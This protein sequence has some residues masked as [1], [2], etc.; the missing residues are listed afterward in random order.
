VLKQGLDVST[1]RYRTG[2]RIPKSGIYRV[3]H[4]EH[5]L[6]EE[7]TLLDSEN[8]PTCSQCNKPVHFQFIREVEIDREGF[9]VRLHQIPPLTPAQAA[10]R[11]DEKK[12]A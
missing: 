11:G 7:V 10:L 9:H 1:I 4:R 6:P 12:A 5:L 8:F 3:F 2:L